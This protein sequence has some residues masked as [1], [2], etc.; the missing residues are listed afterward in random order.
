MCHTV[1]D[2]GPWR[3]HV[4]IIQMKGPKQSL[5]TEMS[6][7]A[8]CYQGLPG[9]ELEQGKP[10][11]GQERGDLQLTSPRPVEAMEAEFQSDVKI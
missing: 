5:L 9:Q 6:D 2:E 1:S 11:G 10:W 7:G 8:N 4:A 3:W